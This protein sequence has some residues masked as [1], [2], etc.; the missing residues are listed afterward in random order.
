[1]NNVLVDT[2]ITVTTKQQKNKG[3]LGVIWMEYVMVKV[4]SYIHMYKQV[5]KLTRC[6]PFVSTEVK[7]E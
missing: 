7:L 2:M 6:L 5:V 3:R 4:E 1:M